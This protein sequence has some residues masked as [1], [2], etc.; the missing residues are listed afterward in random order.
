MTAGAY[1]QLLALLHMAIN[2]HAP[3]FGVV[4]E[5]PPDETVW[6]LSRGLARAVRQYCERRE[7]APHDQ[8]SH[9]TASPERRPRL[10]SHASSGN[11]RTRGQYGEDPRTQ[12][13]D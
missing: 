3:R 12:G 10:E 8:G 2:E 1:R 7:L 11:A 6:R 13:Q 5:N 9:S 4:L